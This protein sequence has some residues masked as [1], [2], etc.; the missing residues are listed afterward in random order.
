MLEHCLIAISMMMMIT[1]TEIIFGSYRHRRRDA[2][3]VY[4][5]PS[6]S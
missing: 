2:Y 5:P 3:S 6:Y 1:L 4:L